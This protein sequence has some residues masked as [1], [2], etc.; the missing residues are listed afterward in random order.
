MTC[1]CSLGL[2][3]IVRNIDGNSNIIKNGKNGYLFNENNQLPNQ[4]LKAEKL[5]NKIKTSRYELLPMKS[6]YERNINRYS[7]LINEI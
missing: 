4:I 2:I 5:K 3:C 1:L 7:N 6:N